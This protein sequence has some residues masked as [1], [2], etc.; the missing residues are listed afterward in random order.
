M[1]KWRLSAIQILELIHVQE[2]YLLPVTSHAI[3]PPCLRKCRQSFEN[4]RGTRP[5]TM[6]ILCNCNSK[7]IFSVAS[8]S[9]HSKYLT[10]NGSPDSLE[11]VMATN[12][13]LFAVDSKIL[14]SVSLTV[15]MCTCKKWAVLLQ[16]WVWYI[17]RSAQFLISAYFITV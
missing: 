15:L 4:S 5:T 17:V 9:S 8:F 3:V 2:R 1:W 13:T 11:N 12:H 6:S 7:S 14:R 16:W 10:N